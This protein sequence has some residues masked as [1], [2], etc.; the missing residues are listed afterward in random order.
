[1]TRLVCPFLAA[2]PLFAQCSDVS[3]DNH[4]RTAIDH[5]YAVIEHATFAK[6]TMELYSVYSPD[7]EAVN[8]DGGVWKFKDSAAYTTSGFDQVK[9]NIHLNNTIVAM[10][11]CKSGEVKA[12]VLQQWTRMQQSFGKLRRFETNTVQD[13]TWVLDG[14]TWMRLRVDNIR[15]GA[16]FID[17][18][19]VNPH[20]PYDPDAPEYNPRN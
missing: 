19:R 15:P 13:E 4:L 20:H 11:S 2:L 7:F 9:E 18:K 12:T 1:M 16:W 6:D 17:G 3:K 10:V 14:D 5:Q 8:I